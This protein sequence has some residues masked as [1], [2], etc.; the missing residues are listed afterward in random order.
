[1]YLAHAGHPWP[2]WWAPAAG[3]LLGFGAHFANVLPD[4]R[5]DAATGVRGLPQ[6]LGARNGVIV[7]ALAL[8]A[9]SVVIGAG[10]A[11]TTTAFTVVACVVGIG[12]AVATAAAARIRPES[13]LAFRLAMLI[14]L[15]DVVLIVTN[16]AIQ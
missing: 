12:G 16:A 3:A 6:R 10:P 15:L 5:D 4:L 9:A 1:M 14:A 7:M 2:P 13:S 8:A 11:K